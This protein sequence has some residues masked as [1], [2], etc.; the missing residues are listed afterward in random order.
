MKSI[1]NHQQSTWLLERVP[2]PNDPADQ[3]GPLV[4][5]AALEGNGRC[6]QDEFTMAWGDTISEKQNNRIRIISHNIAGFPIS[7]RKADN[8]PKE[9]SIKELMNYT[10]ADIALWQEINYNPSNLQTT[11]QMHERSKF[12]FDQ[13]QTT[14]ATNT[15]EEENPRRFLSGGTA[16]WSVNSLSSRSGSRVNDTS[17]LGRWA[18]VKL[19]GEGDH[20]VR[21]FSIYCPTRNVENFDSAH[22]H[23]F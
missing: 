13:L 10:E 22:N 9:I 19:N 20:S 12:W 15:H 6:V 4:D 23:K 7:R 3:L 8:K 1:R 21:V 17:G 11:E 5:Q 14:I 18:S 2:K 16:I